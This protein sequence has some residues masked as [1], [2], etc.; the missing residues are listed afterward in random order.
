MDVTVDGMST[1]A[2]LWIVF[3]EDNCLKL[4]L[5]SG[6][7]DCVDSLQVEIQKQCGVEGEFRLQYMDPDFDQFMNLTSTADI[8]DKGTGKVIMSTEQSAQSAR[9]P[10][11]AAFHRH[12]DAS[13]DTDILSSSE[14]SNS[15]SSLRL[16]GWPRTFPIPSFT[17]DVEMQLS[18]ANRELLG[19][20]HL[21]LAPEP[22]SETHVRH[23][24]CL[25]F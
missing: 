7:P 15:T 11:D 19:N 23:F 25:G 3:G 13:A 17:N 8:E 5:P 22:K 21:G 12:D 24:G 9:Y 14:S 20:R 4:S 6:I 2:K 1:P 16:Q 18:K 10:S